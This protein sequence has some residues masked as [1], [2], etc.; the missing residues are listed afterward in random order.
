MESTHT[1]K[2]KGKDK[3][4][5]NP[6]AKKE[7]GKIQGN[8]ER[9]QCYECQGFDHFAS[10]CPTRLKKKKALAITWDDE[11]DSDEDES[12]SEDQGKEG[13]TIPCFHGGFSH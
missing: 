13:Q 7:K 12:A 11:S 9:A 5:I 10:E 8:S 4:K 3:L 6:I 1:H 2:S